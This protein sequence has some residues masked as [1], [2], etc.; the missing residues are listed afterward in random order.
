MTI[1]VIAN[2]KFLE[3][4]IQAAT[5]ASVNDGLPDLVVTR[6]SDGFGIVNEIINLKMEDRSKSKTERNWKS[7]EIT[8]IMPN[9][10]MFQFYDRQQKHYHYF[11]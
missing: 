4:R 1:G 7:M 11:K 9:Q 10:R 5:N 6:N 3:G 2:G 8:S